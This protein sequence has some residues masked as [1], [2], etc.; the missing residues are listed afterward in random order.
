MK[1]IKRNRVIFYLILGIGFLLI[2]CQSSGSTD[3]K[4]DSQKRSEYLHPGLQRYNE[5]ID[6]SFIGETNENVRDLESQ[7]P[8]ETQIDNRWT[9]LYHDVLGLNIKYDW[10]AESTL[11]HQR[12]V[13]DLTS[14][15]L[16]DLIKVDALQM[17]QLANAGL[18][19]DLTN[20]YETYA[21]PFTREVLSEE[22]IDPIEA[23]MINQKL[24]GIPEVESSLDA[25]QYIWI[26]SDWLAQL[27]LDPPETMADLLAISKAFTHNDPDQNGQDDT[28]G[29]AVSDYW[30][31]NITGL[32]GFM[33]GYEA[34]PNIWLKD[35]HGE[36]V[37][38]GIQPEVKEALSVLREMYN[39]QQIDN[40]F[41]FKDGEKVKEQVINGEVGMFYG[42]QWASFF[43]QDSLKQ[44]PD[45]DWKAY[46]IVSATDQ[47]PKMPI[48][49]KVSKFWVVRADYEHPEAIVKLINLHLEKNWGQTAEYERYYST[50]HPAWQ[51]SPVR[52]FPALKN[53]E[54]YRQIQQAKKEND[55]SILEGEAEKINELMISY[56]ENGDRDGWGWSKTYGSDGA[57][58]ILDQLIEND[59]ILYDELVWP[60][61]ETMI[62]LNNI[63]ANRKLN[64][65]QNII[66][67]D[68]ISEFDQFVEE[69]YEL[70]GIEITKE[71][72]QLYKNHQAN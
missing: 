6:V 65:Y 48:T 41:M 42:E 12:M 72:N 18:I 31:N 1:Q 37:Y 16:P 21:T 30:W 23:A 62:E 45:V 36:L 19:Q 53:L 49:H 9:Q 50:P 33:A 4:T 8:D 13:N 3:D 35:E 15:N 67:G 68:P 38:G 17:R 20:V 70:G 57:Y 61:T 26:R 58:A 11:F 64:T 39:D 59:Q 69:W 25:M 47:P 40:E 10:I 28:F 71:I 24:M 51:L 22:M 60:P 5:T 2:G 55:P 7:F 56:Q 63:L 66:L 52:P 34:Y 14:G 29:L 43:V 32:V 54:A 27:N 44:G 46:P